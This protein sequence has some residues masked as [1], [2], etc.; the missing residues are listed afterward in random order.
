M[1][2]SSNQI[3]ATCRG[4]IAGLVL[5]V[6]CPAA[7]AQAPVDISVGEMAMLPEYCPDTQVFSAADPR[8]TEKGKR[9]TSLLGPAFLGLHHY[10]WGLIHVHRAKQ[11][12]VPAQMRRWH[13]ESAINDYRY[14]ISNSQPGFVLMPEV[15]LRVGEANLELQSNLGALEA[16]QRS[17]ELKPDYW[18]AYVRAATVLMRIG[19]TADAVTLIE[20]GLTH[21]PN[22]PALIDAYKRLG[23]N[24]A[25]FL[26]S[27]Q[28]AAATT[29]PPAA[30]SA[31]P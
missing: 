12:G 5:I 30:S 24:Y 10:C 1:T 18:P 23:G 8:F 4:V 6:G 22:E 9:W 17:R 7:I 21:K 26:Q 25:K 27:L 29:P 20:Q 19:K 13:L 16:F 14:T 11:A 3:A 15:Y 31:R 2:R 28:A